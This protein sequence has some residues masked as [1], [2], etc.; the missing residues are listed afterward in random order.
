MRLKIIFFGFLVSIF[1]QSTAEAFPEMIRHGY[2]NCISCHVSPNGGG[3]LTTYGRQLSR[4]VLSF[5]GKEGEEQFAYGLVTLPP[6]M[7]AG[8][9][10]RGLQFYENNA[11][12][13]QAKAIMMQDDLALG[14]TYG[15]FFL[16]GTIGQQWSPGG[17]PA[18]NQIFSREHYVNY[19]PTDN[20]SLR[21]GKFRLEYGINTP[22]H[23]ISIKRDIG[24]DENTETYNLE[25]SWLGETYNLFLTAD[26]GRPDFLELQK[27]RG[28]AGTASYFISETYKVGM[29]YFTGTNASQTRQLAG[30][31]AVLGFTKH[32]FLLSELDFQYVNSAIDAT[33]Q[34][35][36]VDYQKLDYEVIQGIHGFLSLEY[37]Q[38]DLQNSQTL[39]RSFGIGT[40]LFPRP[41]FELTLAYLKQQMIAVGQDYNDF[42]YAM[43]HFYL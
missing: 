4:E 16:V 30:P 31:F 9:E 12:V 24:F 27:E 26:F 10:F 7:L 40:Q 2:T 8:G 25:A 39:M 19:R 32:F 22:E 38:L 42:A 5:A 33:F 43:L 3:V 36:L 41:H 29:S 20:L 17:P 23:A 34:R 35:G 28:V 1:H 37:S 15:Q 21:L 18:M 13:R 14:A 6:W 11:S